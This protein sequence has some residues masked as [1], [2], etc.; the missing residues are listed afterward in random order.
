MAG[1]FWLQGTPPGTKSDRRCFPGS[2]MHIDSLDVSMQPFLPPSH[3]L[4]SQV[5]ISVLAPHCSTLYGTIATSAHKYIFSGGDQSS[6]QGAVCPNASP[7][8]VDHGVPIRSCHTPLR[9]LLTLDRFLATASFIPREATAPRSV[10]HHTPK[11]PPR[12]MALPEKAS[13]R[14]HVSPAI[15]PFSLVVAVNP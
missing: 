15:R 9:P 6:G 4:I 10:A 13:T 5:G 12:Q 14:G 8:T 3:R 11:D 1:H 7:E 2:D